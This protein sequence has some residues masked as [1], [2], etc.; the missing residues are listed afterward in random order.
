MLAA[1]PRASSLEQGY[2]RQKL[3]KHSNGIARAAAVWLGIGLGACVDYDPA[4]DS[5]ESPAEGEGS[6]GATGGGMLNPCP[7]PEEVHLLAEGFAFVPQC[8][9]REVD[10]KVCSIVSGSRVVWTFA[11]A[12]S[13]NVTSVPDRFGKSSD[14]LQ[15]SWEAVFDEPGEFSYN[16]TLHAEMRGYS[17]VVE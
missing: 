2:S 12:E 9:C 3:K 17:I 6:A 7:N 15:G 10:G 4:F 11:D 5:P 13:H 8:G 1:L 16:C 14:T